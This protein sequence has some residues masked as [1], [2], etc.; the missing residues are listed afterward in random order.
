MFLDES[1]RIKGGKQ[2]KR[3]EAILDIAH[4][5]KKKLVMSGTPMP[6]SPK[7][8]ISQFLFLYPTKDVDENTVID[9]IQPI[10]VRT[11]KGQLNIPE[12]THVVKTVKMDPLQR[13]IYKTLKSEIKRQMNPVLS[14][15]SRYELARQNLLIRHVK[16]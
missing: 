6:Q 9:L 8:L 13:E 14:D 7:D 12:V 10:Y 3:A 11:T 2:V 15:S 4:L 16:C 5:P 1:H